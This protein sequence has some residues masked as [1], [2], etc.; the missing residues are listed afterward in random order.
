MSMLSKLGFN[1]EFSGMTTDSRQVVPG[2]LFLAYPGE[3]RDGRDY[4]A[5][6]IK[7]GASGILWEKAGFSWPEK[8]LVPNF[9][10]V[11]LKQQVGLIAADFYGYPSQKLTMIGVTG[12]NGKTSVSVWIAQCLSLLGKKS[13]VLGT[14]GNGIIEGSDA[15]LAATKNTTQDAVLLQALLT[16]YVAQN[17]QA[18]VME[19][20]SHGLDQGRV[21]GIDFDI[22]VLTNLSRDHLDY[23]KT[24]EAY[25]KAKQ[26]L[27]SW[28]SLVCSVVNADDKFGQDIAKIQ[29]EQHKMYLSYGIKAGDI[30]A[31]DLQLQQQ[32]IS[33]LVTTP[34]GQARLNAPVLGRFNVYNILAVLSTLLALEVSLENAVAVIAKIKPVTGRMQQLGGENMPLVVIDYAH[35]PDAL[36]KALA[37]LREQLGLDRKLICVFGCGGERDAGKRALMGAIATEWAD[38]MIVTSDNPRSENPNDIANQ[39]VSTLT[40]SYTVELDRAKAISLAVA[41]AQVGDIVLVAGKGHEDYQE[42]AGVKLPFSDFVVAQLALEKLGAGRAI[43]VTQ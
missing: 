31:S 35:T 10:I 24:M 39:I 42:I 36:E 3:H 20:S 29:K 19:V 6:A 23:H 38:E 12:T 16:S 30:R 21:N 34:Q 17:T 4:I 26:T 11:G 22:A 41:G 5:E 1:L 32:G 7:A 40:G 2:N 18:V 15:T 25:A 27:F 8:F 37:T 9:A 33:M 43:G 28:P 14:I 13:A